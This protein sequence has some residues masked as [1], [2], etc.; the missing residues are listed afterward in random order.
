MILTTL[1]MASVA[2]CRVSEDDLREAAR[3][4]PAGASKSRLIRYSLLCLILDESE[5]HS[6]VFGDPDEITTVKGSINGKLPA[7]EWA[8]IQQ[9]YPGAS[10]AELVRCGLALRAGRNP[11]KVWDL[12]KVPRGPRPKVKADT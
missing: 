1:G 6:T 3:R 2:A 9:T 8:L 12:A 10:M 5:A 11:L 4:V 7:H